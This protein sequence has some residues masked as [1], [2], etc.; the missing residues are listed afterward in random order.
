MF[1]PILTENS[2]I[3]LKD[4]QCN[5]FANKKC[6]QSSDGIMERTNE[7]QL[8][9]ELTFHALFFITSAWKLNANQS[10]L[11]HSPCKF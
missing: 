3:F 4:A 5:L 1:K 7:G 8:F 6:L 10:S 2:V 9:T 11:L